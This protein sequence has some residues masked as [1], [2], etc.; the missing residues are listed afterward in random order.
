MFHSNIDIVYLTILGLDIQSIFVATPTENH[1]YLPTLHLNC[2]LKRNMDCCTLFV[3]F[4]LNTAGTDS[5][6]S[7]LETQPRF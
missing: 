4:D 5:K 2:T 6:D 1:A 3:D 7:F